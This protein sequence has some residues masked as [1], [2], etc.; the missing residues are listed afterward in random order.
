MKAKELAELLMEN[1][2]LDVEVSCCET[3]WSNGYE[4]TVYRTF[5]DIEVNV[6]KTT[7]GAIVQIDCL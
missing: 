3:V 7:T 2:D 4:H 5:E 6:M 1:P